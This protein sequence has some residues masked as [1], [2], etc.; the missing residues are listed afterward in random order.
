[1][2]RKTVKIKSL[3]YLN[4]DVIQIIT[5]R[6]ENYTFKPGQAT[7]V[8]IEK[9]GWKEEKRPFTFTS[10][11]ED[12]D[13]QFIIKIYPSHNGVTEQLATL[14]TGDELTLGDVYGAIEYKG[15]G[16]FLAGGAGITPFI[17]ILKSLD[18]K[19]QV[20]GNS[21]VFANKTTK[22]IFY[23]EH[24]QS[25]LGRQYLNILSQEKTKDYPHGHIDEAFLQS[26][27]TDVSKY[28]Y[29]CGPPKMTKAIVGNLHDLGVKQKNIV[30]E[31]FE[32]WW[33]RH[34]S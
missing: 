11:P 31:N 21:I 14:T 4:H 18:K 13:L 3:E 16:I 15:K 7:D 17:S 12:A 8:S 10:L 32:D 20:Q 25:L 33:Y 2:K 9:N 30:T 29:V 19:K 1:M 27:V 23:Q 24:L 5:D 22:D 26:M 6:P 28:F 34:H